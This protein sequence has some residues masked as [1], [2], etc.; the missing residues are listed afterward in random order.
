MPKIGWG[1]PRNDPVRT[2]SETSRPDSVR[3][4]VTQSGTPRSPGPTL[5]QIGRK[6]S[7]RM[8]SDAALIGMLDF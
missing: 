8:F 7:V 2:I 4:T 3:E 5:N 1:T 6:D